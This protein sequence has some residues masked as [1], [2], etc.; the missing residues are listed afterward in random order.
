MGASCWFFLLGRVI[1]YWGRF[2]EC[3]R[4]R[5]AA[6]VGGFTALRMPMQSVPTLPPTLQNVQKVYEMNVGEAISLPY[7]QPATCTTFRR[8]GF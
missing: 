2:Q 8:G 7:I 1:F 6:A 5:R 3:G 4:L